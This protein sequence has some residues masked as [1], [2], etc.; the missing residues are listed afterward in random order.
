MSKHEGTE[1][2]P[3]GV[4]NYVDLYN[5]RFALNDHFVQQEDIELPQI[6]D[7]EANK[8]MPKYKDYGWDPIGN[9]QLIAQETYGS[10]INAERGSPFFSYIRIKPRHLC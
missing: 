3:W 2:N 5:V 7:V 10:Y 9:G 4:Y 8:I 1:E 6:D